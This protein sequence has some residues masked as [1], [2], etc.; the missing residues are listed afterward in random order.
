MREP[1]S[2][3]LI[4]PRKDDLQKL[5]SALDL[6]NLEWTLSANFSQALQ[7]LEHEKPDLILIWPR[8]IQESPGHT[9][10]V[11]RSHPSSMRALLV[12]LAVGYE[13]PLSVDWLCVG[14]DD[15]WALS[16]NPLVLRSRLRLL[17]RLR[18]AHQ[19]L[20]IMHEDLRGQREHLNDVIDQLERVSRS[21]LLTG[22]PNRQKA[23]ERFWEESLRFQR[24]AR[25]FSLVLVD[26]DG[27]HL[28]NEEC[29]AD[30]GDFVLR[31]I[32]EV[33]LG[34]IRRQD[35]ISRWQADRFML[36]L[37]ETDGDGARILAEKIRDLIGNLSLRHREHRIAITARCGVV[38]YQAEF[39]IEGNLSRCEK[40]L[41]EAKQL[42]G[43][44]VVA[45][46]SS[47]SA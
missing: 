44:L 4:D 27:F 9:L 45:D 43:N 2:V 20:E 36:M 10:E 21:D 41:E 7:V 5:F 38:A 13:D 29:G 14:Y 42:G 23:L 12:L 33:I 1:K 18:E 35:V 28:I 16:Q 25:D 15:L 39:G 6:E 31:G 46:Y 30:A 19:D 47:K 22:L 32:A 40:A 26:V 37:P 17:L 3:L 24:S 8:C 11:L 34:N